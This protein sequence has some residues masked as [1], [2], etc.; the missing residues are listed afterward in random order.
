MKHLSEDE[1]E[2]AV[3]LVIEQAKQLM[4]ISLPEN[5]ESMSRA[6]LLNHWSEVNA[7]RFKEGE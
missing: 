4:E 1:V 2:A 6:E 5:W 3:R 7:Q